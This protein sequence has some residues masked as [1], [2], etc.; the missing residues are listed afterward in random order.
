MMSFFLIY[1]NRNLHV[2]SI[3]IYSMFASGDYIHIEACSSL[4]LLYE[5]VYMCA[6]PDDVYVSYMCVC[7]H[8]IELICSALNVQRTLYNPKGA[9]KIR[10]SVCVFPL[11]GVLPMH[12]HIARYHPL[13]F[14]QCR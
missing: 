12:I 14:V 5:S 8:C 1:T 4:E 3:S 9:H 6:L 10:W 7:L 11:F 2:H 13:Y